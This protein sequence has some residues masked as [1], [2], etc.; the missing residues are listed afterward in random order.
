MIPNDAFD[1]DEYTMHITHKIQHLYSE[2]SEGG[3]PFNVY[4]FC[5]KCGML[6][7][8]EEPSKE[9][10]HEYTKVYGVRGKILECPACF[11]RYGN[12]EVVTPVK[13]GQASDTT[14]LTTTLF[15]DFE[16]PERKTLIF[17]DNR[18]D[19]AH[20]AGYM[21][22]RHIQF[23]IRQLLYQITKNRDIPLSIKRAAEG[24]WEKGISLGIFDRPQV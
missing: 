19:A 21:E 22:D 14:V 2:D 13:S 9:C 6:S 17:S 1:S 8:S 12:R 11:G 3:S 23:T 4:Y 24:V 5:P 7:I 10:K 16:E 18:Q 15:S 20:Q